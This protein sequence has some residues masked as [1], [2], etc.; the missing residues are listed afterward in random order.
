MPQIPDKQYFRP[1]EVARIIEEK[2]RTVRY[3]LLV[4]RIKHIHHGKKD[5]V[6]R[7]EVERI[8]RNGV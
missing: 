8:V 3:W 2:V 6:T 1:D 5:V 4:G 7:E